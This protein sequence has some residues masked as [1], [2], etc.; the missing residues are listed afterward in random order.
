MKY[1]KGLLAAI[2]YAGT[3]M[4]VSVGAA[5]STENGAQTDATLVFFDADRL[6]AFGVG[7]RHRSRLQAN[8][9]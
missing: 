5:I 2:A 4:V 1:S 3:S 8:K 9:C 6:P 7:A